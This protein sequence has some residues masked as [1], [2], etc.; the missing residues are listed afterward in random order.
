MSDNIPTY[1]FKIGSP[2]REAGAEVPVHQVLIESI[3]SPMPSAAAKALSP[4]VIMRTSSQQTQMQTTQCCKRKATKTC[5]LPGLH[6]Q[7]QATGYAETL[8]P[9]WKRRLEAGN[10]SPPVQ[11]CSHVWCVQ[12]HSERQGLE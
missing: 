1:S 8:Q 4:Y 3:D 11:L 10:V 6:S 7:L 9:S 12:V 5:L 2:S